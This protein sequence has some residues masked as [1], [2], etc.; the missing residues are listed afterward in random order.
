MTIKKYLTTP[1]EVLALKDTDTKIYDYFKDKYYKFV[2]GILC[3]FNDKDEILLFN[4]NL[5]L[6][7]LKNSYPYILIEEP[8]SN[9][10]EKDI[11]KLCWFWDDEDEDT[12]N[13]GVLK[14]IRD[15]KFYINDLLSYDNCKRLTFEE[16][17]E[18]T[19]YMEK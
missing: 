2:G 10:T 13:Y 1:E 18:L 17:V 3:Y 14:Y 15:E 11:G 4:T 8:I 19:G 6:G 12:G 7:H 5:V 9:A 16:I